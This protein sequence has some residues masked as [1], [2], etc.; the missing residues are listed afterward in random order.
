MLVSEPKRSKYRILGLIGRGQFGRVYC[1]VHR[2]TGRLVA[3][4]ALDHDCFPTHKFLRELHFLLRLQHPNI[5]TFE[6]IEHVEGGRYLVMDYCE[7]GTLRSL[8]EN[9]DQLNPALSIKLVCD[10]LAGIGHAHQ[11][12]IVHCD[13]KPENILLHL[14]PQGWM[15]RVSDFGISRFS[16]E[17]MPDEASIT[18]S[19][20]YMA[21]ERFYGQ[22]S[23]STDLYAI[24]VL[25]YEL[26]VGDRPFS[27]PPMELRMAHLNQPVLIPDSIPLPLQ[28]VILTALQKLKARR[29]QSASTMLDALK[30]A[31]KQ[32]PDLQM[33]DTFA[34]PL[35]V[36][37]SS[38]S[39]L[40]EETLAHSVEHLAIA[41]V[42]P[43][44]DYDRYVRRSSI[45]FLS[46]VNE[47][48]R[49]SYFQGCLSS[50]RCGEV[51]Q[52]L[53]L[54]EA[55]Q[56]LVVRS[57]GCYAVTA[58]SLYLLSQ[59]PKLIT[60]FDQP[61]QIAI[62]PQEYWIATFVVNVSNATLSFRK[63]LNERFMQHAIAW[64]R[65]E[66]V[67]KLLALNSRHV[68]AFSRL[69]N[70][71]RVRIWNRR[72]QAI[73]SLNFPINVENVIQTPDSYCL[74]ATEQ[75]DL[76]HLLFIHLKPLR[77]TRIAIDILPKFLTAFS[78][79]VVAGNVEGQ[80]VAVD[81]DGQLLNQFQTP[82]HVCAVASYGE[83]GLLLSTRHEGQGTLYSLKI[84]ANSSC[85]S[86]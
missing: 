59:T 31:V 11:Q 17:L 40:R 71:T 46:D 38:V 80:F 67:I 58:R 72:G 34:V 49:R 66:V 19:P 86:E 64:E 56:D 24:G 60:R 27:G 28:T 22:Y 16:Q 6:A 45:V 12:G 53:S 5:V 68:A 36:P 75:R 23:Q 51:I 37:T 4:K 43:L 1:A 33:S 76:K 9:H 39:V 69:T 3:L 77:L 61:S 47:I 25:L 44:P 18:G 29:F 79:G 48:H 35:G 74:V 84:S 41:D 57:Q 21:P 81:Y 50:S 73:T 62:D 42:S 26:L 8:I 30:M 83:T 14:Q 2:K 65:K 7:A 20:A 52:V 63:L 55:V 78:W 10:V 82:N 15:A 85:T 32:C 13:I 54:S 70:E